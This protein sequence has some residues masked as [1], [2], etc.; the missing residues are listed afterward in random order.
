MPHKIDR[1]FPEYSETVMQIQ[2]L[3]GQIKTRAELNAVFVVVNG[4][5]RQ[6]EVMSAKKFHINQ[7]VSFMNNGE[8]IVGMVAKINPKTIQVKVMGDGMRWRVSPTLLMVE[9]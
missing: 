6:L 5:A 8:K 3:L 1:T 9:E 7:V 2:S 4:R